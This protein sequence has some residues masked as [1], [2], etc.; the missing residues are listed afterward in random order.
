MDAAVGS[1][2]DAAHYGPTVHRPP[3]R[4][5]EPTAEPEA[6]RV[7]SRNSKHG[8]LSMNNGMVAGIYLDNNRKTC[9]A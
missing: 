1:V 9:L 2:M 7:D 5:R 4:P 8:G 3:P 6:G